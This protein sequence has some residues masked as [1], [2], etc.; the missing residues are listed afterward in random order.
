MPLTSAAPLHTSR[1]PSPD[2]AVEV[3]ES[4]LRVSWGDLPIVS[5]IALLGWRP[6]ATWRV[7]VAAATG[8]TQGDHH[9]LRS[10]TFRARRLPVVHSVSL[11]VTVNGQQY[12]VDD[13]PFVYYGGSDLQG[14]FGTPHSAPPVISSASPSAGPIAG[15]TRVVLRGSNLAGG[16]E[17]VCSFNGVRGNGSFEYSAEEAALVAQ[18]S[19]L[20]SGL[21]RITCLLPNA[22]A[23]GT[24]VL[25]VALN[26]QQFGGGIDY[27]YYYGDA[28]ITAVTPPTGPM[29]GGTVLRLHGVNLELGAHYVC[30]IGGVE[31]PASIAPSSLEDYSEWTQR[32]DGGRVEEGIRALVGWPAGCTPA[33]LDRDLAAAAR[34]RRGGRV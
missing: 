1:R 21:G 25:R 26:A 3:A 11:K 12:T 31:R 8:A 32:R 28:A 17:Y 2:A 23:I 15:G 14:S 7:C 30:V 13:R 16:S 19:P 18:S 4:G 9:W 29:A 24:V 22:S 34:G 27:V 5:E 33:L 6:Q 20:A 10:L